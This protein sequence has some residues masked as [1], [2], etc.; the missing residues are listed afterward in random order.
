MKSIID[1][2]EDKIETYEALGYCFYLG[3]L[4]LFYFAFGFTDC[5]FYNCHLV[6]SSLEVGEDRANVS[7]IL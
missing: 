1:F 4:G 3:L 5:R 2:A 6:L 7:N